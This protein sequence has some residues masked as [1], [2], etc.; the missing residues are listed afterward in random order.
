[1]IYVG[2]I[3]ESSCSGKTAELAYQ[4]GTLLARAGVVLVTG[5]LG[6]VMES[7]CRGAKEAGGV[8]LGILPAGDRSGENPYLDYSIPTGLGEARN[9]IVVRCSDALLAV[10]GSY[11]TLSEIAF[12]LRFGKP[13]V[14]LETWRLT[15][16]GGVSA[17]VVYAADPDSAVNLVLGLIENKTN[18]PPERA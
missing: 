16:G 3:G 17:P 4:A 15:N 6:G 18:S 13:V 2:I 8:T 14:G 7:S 5:G 9:S 10:G 11:G 12:A 1:M